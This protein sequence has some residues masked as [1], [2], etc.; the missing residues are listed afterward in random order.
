MGVVRGGGADGAAHQIAYFLRELAATE[1]GRRASAVKGLGRVGRWAAA[2]EDVVADVREAV[3]RAAQDP[4]AVVRAGAADA[5]GRLGPVGG[6]GAAAVV[7]ALMG[8]PDGGVRRRA[9]LA[10]ERLAL[11]GPDVVGAFRRLMSDDSDWH[12]RLNGLLGVT[13]REGA[14]DPTVLIRLLGDTGT[15]VWGQARTALYPLLR[16]GPVREQVLHTARQGRGL[17]RARA[18]DMLPSKDL[19]RLRGSLVEGLRD[20]CPAV[21]GMAASKLSGDRSSRTVDAILSALAAETDA[22]AARRMLHTLGWWGEERALPLAVRWLDHPHPGSTA[23]WALARIDTPEAWEWIRT[24]VVSGPGPEPVPG[25]GHPGV[26]DAAAT[27]LGERGDA[28]TTELLLPLLHDPDERIRR[29]AVRGLMELGRHRLRRRRR[30]PVVEALLGLLTTDEAILP[31]TRDALSNYPEALPAVRQLIDHPSD[32]VRAVVVS[33]LDVDEDGDVRLLLGHLH[34]PS[35]S[36]RYQALYGISRYVDTYGELPDAADR[37]GL[38]GEL[39][40][41]AHGPYSSV[42]SFNIRLTAGRILDKLKVEGKA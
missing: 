13:R 33:L 36:V 39:K 28:R 42:T 30:R 4:A 35:E 2:Y 18:L 40:A 26:R 9:S 21:R 34:D 25:R 6:E 37:A 22:E 16:Q 41:L 27:A 10:A 5:L 19:D 38:L 14:P 15:H 1:P 3:L 31:H 32:E 12:L 17:S 7:V 20:E 24:V 23:V 29:G 11:E 8:D